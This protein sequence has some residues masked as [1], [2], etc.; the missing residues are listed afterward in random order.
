MAKKS[1]P[2]RRQ[3]PRYPTRHRVEAEPLDGG[4]AFRG[5]LQ[6]LSAAGCCL[7]LDRP[8]SL[9]TQIEL[10]CDIGGLGLRI[11]GR[12]VW[13]EETAAGVFHGIALAGYESEEDALFHRLY[14]GR[15]A[16][17]AEGAPR[18]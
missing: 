9:G 7:R 1:G 6:D 5:T 14:L 16:H 2:E 4:I 11:R 12:V 3:F 8:V 17:Q 10:R 15:L 13:A 18:G